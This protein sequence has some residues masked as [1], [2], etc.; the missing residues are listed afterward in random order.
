[1]A[2]THALSLVKTY[3]RH[4]YNV[5]YIHRYGSDEAGFDEED[6]DSEE[7]YEDKDEDGDEEEDVAEVDL[8][9]TIVADGGSDFWKHDEGLSEIQRKYV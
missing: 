4:L 1:L 5:F 3:V 9:K 7:D 2:C 6:E 8:W